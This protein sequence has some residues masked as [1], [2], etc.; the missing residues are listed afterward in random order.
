MDPSIFKS[1]LN[2]CK[3]KIPNPHLLYTVLT[4]FST[5]VADAIFPVTTRLWHLSFV[6][7]QVFGVTD[8]KLTLAQVGES[9]VDKVVH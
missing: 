6:Y 4:D 2:K 3:K 5:I 1:N 8:I 7:T 9:E